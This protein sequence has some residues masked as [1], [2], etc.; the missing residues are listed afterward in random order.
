MAPANKNQGL[1]IPN[2]L[3]FGFFPHLRACG[4]STWCQSYFTFWDLK[5]AQHI[6]VKAIIQVLSRAYQTSVKEPP[7]PT[8]VFQP[9]KVSLH[10]CIHS[11]RY[12]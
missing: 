8:L 5:I 12:Q 2:S 1:G 10:I 3:P 6:A 9:R 4:Q 11:K 7:V